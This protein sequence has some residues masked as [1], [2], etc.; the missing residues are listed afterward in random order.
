MSTIIFFFIQLLYTVQSL[1]FVLATV[2]QNTAQAGFTADFLVQVRE[3]DNLK[4]LFFHVACLSTS[5]NSVKCCVKMEDV[6]KTWVQ[7]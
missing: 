6:L 5:H 4:I 1:S 7:N 3:V 2:H